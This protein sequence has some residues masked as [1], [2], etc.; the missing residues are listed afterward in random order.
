LT[1]EKTCPVVAQVI[2][3]HFRENLICRVITGR[4]ISVSI[5]SEETSAL[6]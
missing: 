4:G 1:F 2:S 5:Y 3:G 6:G